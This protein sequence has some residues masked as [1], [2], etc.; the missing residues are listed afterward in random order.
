MTTTPRLWKS[1]TQVN[2]TDGGET[3][4]NGQ[5]I[6]LNN[7]GYVVVWT[8]W[9]N[10]YNPIGAAI[11]GQ[12]Y[13]VFGNKVGGEVEISQFDSGSQLSPAVTRLSNGNIAVAFVDNFK[14]DSI[15][16]GQAIYVRIYNP[17]LGLIETYVPA[18]AANV[19][20]PSIT[21]LADGGFAISYTKVNSADDTDIVARIVSSTGAFGP[22]FDVHNQSDNS[23]SSQTATLSNGNFVVVYEDEF[24][25]STTDHDI[26]FR[27]FTPAGTPVLGPN[28]Y[29]VVGGNGN[30]M[31]A[32]PDVAALKNGGFVVVWEDDGGPSG[33]DIRA[34]IYNNAGGTVATD[35]LVETTTIGGQGSPNV[36][37][38]GDGGF[39][40][41]WHS[42]EDL[43][44]A[45]RFDADGAKIGAEFI[46][47]HGDGVGSPEATLLADGRIAYAINDMHLPSS[48]VEVVTS[49]WDPR[50]TVSNFDGINQ[51]DF[52]WQHDNGLAAVWLLHD[53]SV[54]FNGAVGPN[55]GPSWH[56]I[57]DGDFNADGRSEFLWQNDSGQAAVWALNNG[58][59]VQYSAAVGGNPG[60]S[61]HVIDTGDFNGDGKSDILWQG[62]DGTPSIWL[63]NGAQATWMG[64]AGSL[65]PGPTWQIKG[66][67][68]FNGDG[69]SDILWQGDDGTPSIWL[70]NGAQSTWV[71]AVGPFASGALAGWHIKGTG[72]F[73]GDNKSDI[74]WQ[75]DDGQAAIWLMNGTTV[76]G[77][78][79]AGFNPGADWHVVGS[80][81]FNNSDANSDILWQNDDG[82][83][84]VYLMDGM[85]VIGSTGIGGT[86][87]ADWHLIT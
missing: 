3:Q 40:V 50:T 68:D 33:A 47:Q 6:G 60:P 82:Q 45:Q 72:D 58:T 81:Q 14:A 10:A 5:I 11:V 7:G 38:L 31:E 56:L 20:A 9:S 86:P 49:I 83:A 65:N 75:G 23:D 1:L 84:A 35:L 8:D 54:A 80:G 41:T 27:I 61:W 79:A 57:G 42:W 62:D 18:V 36:V 66:T 15:G 4:N 46:V 74:L 2:A 78:G 17:S 85:G 55:L 13:D 24:N 87:G 25:G 19:S 64:A 52:L 26:L 30:G 16:V 71:G 37:A 34:T 48:D 70:M 21:A 39:V 51:S 69:K 53:T 22:Q 28:P 12:R 77:L 32:W 43:T 44:R 76:I 73:N 59:T 67:G 63:M 29:N